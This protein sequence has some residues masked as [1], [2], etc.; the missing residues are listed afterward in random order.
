[1]RTAIWGLTVVMVMGCGTAAGQAAGATPQ[2]ETAAVQAEFEV[3]TIRPSDPKNCCGYFWNV[4][5]MRFRTGNTSLR[6]LIRFAYGLNDK[7]I[8]GEPAWADD[9]LYDVTG[10]FEGTKPPTALQCRSALQ[11]LLAERF[12]LKFHHESRGMSAYVLT[13]PRGSSKLTRSG[14]KKDN[15]EQLIFTRTGESGKTMH[16]LGRDVSLQEFAGE[17]QRLTLN[18]P[19]V[20]RTGFAGKF[21]IDLEFTW[22]DQNSLGLTELPDDAAPNLLTALN[23]QLG[24]KLEVA[25]AP[26]DVLVIDHAEPPSAN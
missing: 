9:D 11:T 3:A 25:K 13:A 20:D 5:G 10:G 7:Q 4:D 6:W 18:K 8:I 21:D 16:G 1:M 19:L 12:G 22:E 14:P 17:I 26:V 15:E 24:L 2:T 23:Q